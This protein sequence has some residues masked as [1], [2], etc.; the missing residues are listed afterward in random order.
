MAR[1]NSIHAN[2]V[3]AAYHDLLEKGWLELRRGS[4]LYVRP[5]QQAAE[6][7][8]R[9]LQDLLKAART[10]GYEP[11]HV[12]QRLH[13]MVRPVRYET[14]VVAE[15]DPALR[16]ILCAEIVEKLGIPAVD[17]APPGGNSIVVAL[18]TRL[19]KVRKQLP[20][21]LFCLPLR[22]RS[23][24]ASLEGQTRPAPDTLISIVSASQE[25]RF[26]ARAMLLAV[27]L[28][29]D[30]LQEVGANQEGWRDRLGSRTVVV[31]DILTARELPAGCIAKVFRIIADSSL[32]ELRQLCVVTPP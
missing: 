17:E 21:G 8:D 12:L 27:G 5:L 31:T 26:W 18:A 32:E 28:E 29:P 4:G 13:Q 20:A 24:P 15:D 22:L 2:T 9:I 7:L 30:G 11:E 10:M 1:R 16:T 6:P 3:S 25:I 14:V 19:P 23:V